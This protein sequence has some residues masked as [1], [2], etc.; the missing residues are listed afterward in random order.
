MGH[1]LSDMVAFYGLEN[2]NAHRALSDV[3]A[4]KE[5]FDR[6]WEDG[7]LQYMGE[8]NLLRLFD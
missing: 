4:T 1:K 2:K 8:D 5:V 6:L 3:Y 7:L